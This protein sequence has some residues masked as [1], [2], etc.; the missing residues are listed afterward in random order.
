MRGKRDLSLVHC[1][2]RGVHRPRIPW[3]IWEPLLYRPYDLEFT[4]ESDAIKIEYRVPEDDMR[5]EFLKNDIHLITEGFVVGRDS[6]GLTSD[7]AAF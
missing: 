1:P 5:E 2:R 7:R 4:D 6:V 3:S